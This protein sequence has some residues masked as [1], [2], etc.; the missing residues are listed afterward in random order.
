MGVVEAED[1]DAKDD[2]VSGVR[3]SGYTDLAQLFA[4][5]GVCKDLQEGSGRKRSRSQT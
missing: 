3:D 2:L 1:A 5:A 4:K